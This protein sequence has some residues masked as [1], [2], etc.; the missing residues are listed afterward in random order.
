MKTYEKVVTVVLFPVVVLL[1]V[2]E[3]LWEE[4][5]RMYRDSELLDNWKSNFKRIKQV[6]FVELR[7]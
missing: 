1:A 6:Y 5:C 3:P 4:L 2:I 7:K